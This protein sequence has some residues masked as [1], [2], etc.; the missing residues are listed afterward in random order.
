MKKISILIIG[1]LTII[2]GLFYANIDK[3]TY[4]YDRNN[5]ENN[6]AIG[7][8][9]EEISQEFSVKEDTI[10]ALAIKGQYI[11]DVT[12]KEL[13]LQL[14]DEDNNV[15]LEKTIKESE[16]ANNKF[17]ELPF[18]VIKDTANKKLTLVLRS[19]DFDKN[20]GISFVKNSASTPEMKLNINDEDTDGTL[21]F[22][23]ITHRFDVETFVIF[24][25]FIL[26]IFVFIRVLYR[27]FK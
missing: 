27:L 7:T 20:N 15:L 17:T 4:I 24:V 23:T 22:K 5:E 19:I 9:E 18:D 26:Y 25:L 1:A 11:G 21:V 16:L 8:V 14:V 12:N 2:V 6:V 13:E 3:K 10:N